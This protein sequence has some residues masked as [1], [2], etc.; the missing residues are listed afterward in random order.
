MCRNALQIAGGGMMYDT[1]R[2]I[3]WLADMNYAQTS[4]HTCTGGGKNSAL[5]A[6]AVRPGDMA[7]SVPKPQTLALTLLAL[8]ATVVARRRRPG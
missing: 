3:T 2:N 7:A 4:G 6:A 8:G 5:Y 1:T